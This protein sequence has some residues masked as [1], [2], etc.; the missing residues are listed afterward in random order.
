MKRGRAL[1]DYLKTKLL[2]TCIA[3]FVIA[4]VIVEEAI[5]SISW[6]RERRKAPKPEK[7]DWLWCLVANVRDSSRL[8]GAPPRKRRGGCKHFAPGTRVYVYD[9]MW[10]DGG[11]R[12]LVLGKKKG[13][14]QLVR[15]VV[16]ADILTNFRLKRV[17]SPTVI[18]WMQG[19]KCSFE[20]RH[21]GW[22]NTD[23]DR[24]EI[25][26]TIRYQREYEADPVGYMERI[27]ANARWSNPKK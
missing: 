2:V 19:D 27:Y 7:P 6:A 20:G 12:R 8:E 18:D 5:V 15:K 13:T 16:D 3:P 4:R 17:Y 14:H 11:E 10:G 1:S 23:K 24:N 21:P 9:I 26:E 22:G 25:L